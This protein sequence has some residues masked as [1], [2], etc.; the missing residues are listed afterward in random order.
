MNN[1]V[2]SH[3]LSAAGI[4]G[5]GVGNF[6]RITRPANPGVAA[7]HLRFAETFE[8]DLVS[9]HQTD[10]TSVC[11]SNPRM[12]ETR[13]AL[14]PDHSVAVCYAAAL[15]GLFL[16]AG[17]HSKTQQYDHQQCYFQRLHGNSP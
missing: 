10:L 8:F 3:T 9:D 11:I 1:R 13:L 15:G 4:P 16:T 14:L 6:Y 5:P 7:L 17:N 2:A 12:R